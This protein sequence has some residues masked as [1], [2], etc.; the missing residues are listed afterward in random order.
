M[1]TNTITKFDDGPMKTLTWRANTTR[2]TAMGVDASICLKALYTV[3]VRNSSL[4]WVL[5][6]NGHGIWGRKAIILSIHYWPHFNF[7]HI[8]I[9]TIKN[10]MD[11]CGQA[12]DWSLKSGTSCCQSTTAGLDTGKYTCVYCST[13]HLLS[14]G[15]FSLTGKTKWIYV[16]NSKFSKWWYMY[17]YNLQYQSLIN[18]VYFIFLLL[19]IKANWWKFLIHQNC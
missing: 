4:L 1:P 16:C 17:T 12:H 14:F 7:K 6:W 2:Q 5:Y 18:F 15:Y 9:F 3:E 8:L 11:N 19:F 13:V 10:L